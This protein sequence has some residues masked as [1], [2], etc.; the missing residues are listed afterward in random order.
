MLFRSV[1]GAQPA[2]VFGGIAAG[3][4][5]RDGTAAEW[6]A[7]PGTRPGPLVLELRLINGTELR[8]QAQALTL[9][10]GEGAVFH[11]GATIQL[12]VEARD[13]DGSITFVEF[14][15]GTNLLGTAIT[16]MSATANAPTRPGFPPLGPYFMTWPNVPP[17]EYLLTARVVD[18]AGVPAVSPPIPI[19]VLTNEPLPPPPTPTNHPVAFTIRAIDAYASEGTNALGMRNTAVFRVRRTGDTNSDVTVSYAIDGTASNGVDYLELPGTVTIPSGQRHAD[20]VVVPIDD[21]EIEPVE[22]VVLTLIQPVAG[23]QVI[24]GPSVNE[25]AALGTPGGDRAGRELQRAVAF[26][27]DNDGP[28]PPTQQS[29][30]GFFHVTR[31]ATNGFHYRVEV[32]TNFTGWL[33]VH[34]NTVLDGAVHFIDPAGSVNGLRFYRIVPQPVEST[35]E[36]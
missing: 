6:L 5:L 31:N 20:I 13:P 16:P 29:R 11:A 2:E 19:R 27:V 1:Q 28:R 15:S 35:P 3:R 9:E 12:A 26:I 4:L 8:L 18:D 7:L 23:D 32:S 22:T 10:L 25:L 17:G 30:D 21:D 36:D 33:P 24:G 34:T 14:Y